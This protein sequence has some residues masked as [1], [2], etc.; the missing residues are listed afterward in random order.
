MERLTHVFNQIKESLGIFFGIIFTFLTPIQGMLMTTGGFVIIDTIFAIYV[1]VKLSGWAGYKSNK[2]F[3]IA[4]KTFFYL[5]GIILG[6]CVDT[7]LVDGKIW[8]I[9][10]LITKF[11]CFF[12]IYIEL[13]S[14]D[15]TSMKLGNR[16]FWIVL[17]EAILKAKAFKKDLNEITKKE[18]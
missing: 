16:S 4:P 6:F 13:K 7:F 15:E 10:L 17:K 8:G 5:L 18:E 11:I 12:F 2:L 9:S 1:V 3:N 14:I